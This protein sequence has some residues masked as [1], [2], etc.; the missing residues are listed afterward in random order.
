MA[1]KMLRERTEGKG[2]SLNLQFD[3]KLDKANLK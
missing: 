3:E 2:N 1:Q